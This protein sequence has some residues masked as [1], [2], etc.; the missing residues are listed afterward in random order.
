MAECPGA[1]HLASTRDGLL[2]RIRV[3]GGR[4]SAAQMKTVATLAH[5]LG[6]GLIDFTN[7]A[8]LQI[9]GLNNNSAAQFTSALKECGLLARSEEADRY[10][11]I[12]ASPLAGLEEA[13]KLDTTP[14]VIALDEALQSAPW[15]TN[16]S[17]KFSF[18]FDG[19]GAFS[20]HSVPHDIGFFAEC[21]ASDPLFRVSIDN[22]LS[23][24]LV[25][26]SNCINLGL[27]LAEFAAS[28]KSPRTGRLAGKLET[29]N[30]DDLIAKASPKLKESIIR[31]PQPAPAEHNRPILTGPFP[32]RQTG[33]TVYGLGVMLAQ[34]S[35]KNAHDLAELASHYGQ[36]HLRLSPWQ[37]VF[38]PGVPHDRVHGLISDARRSGFLTEPNEDRIRVI[39][40]SGEP[41]CARTKLD[42]KRHGRELLQDLLT[43]NSV[44]ASKLQPAT[45]HLSG[46]PRGCAHPAPSDILFAARED[47]TGYDTYSDSRPACPSASKRLRSG[48]NNQEILD[49]VL[50]HLT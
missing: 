13:E 6:N 43:H 24:Y 17:P 50:N 23:D 10:R 14:Y 47:G 3:P 26:P 30:I 32:Q 40:C 5:K 33:L 31:H 42:T 21:C 12:T 7:R 2:A 29:I 38:I 41:G 37:A 18:V 22:R 39:A 44:S 28:S 36:G 49:V 20:I 9:R 45:V 35:S 19:G 48:I 25:E 16:L 8:N 4:I 15:I 34:I 46:C 11:N 1:I 27:A